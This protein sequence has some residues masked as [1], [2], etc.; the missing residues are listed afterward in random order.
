M[1]NMVGVSFFTILSVQTTV[2][3]IGND[4]YLLVCQ[5]LKIAVSVSKYRR[6][7]DSGNTK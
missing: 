2:Y 3:A 6:L 4:Y 5:D 1:S 7:L